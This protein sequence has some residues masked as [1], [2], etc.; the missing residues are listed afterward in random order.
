[1]K[2][3]LFE[4]FSFP[5]GLTLR[6]HVVMAP[7]TTWSANDD[8]TVSGEE[9]SYYRRRAQGVGLVLTGCTHVTANGVGF[10]GEFASYDDKFIPSLRRLAN[11][12][13]SGGAPAVLQ[14][15]HAG[16]KAEPNLVPD[17]DVVSASSVPVAAGP[18]NPGG[19][20]PRPLSHDEIL[21]V[22]SAFGAAT[23]RAIEAGFDGIELHGAHGFLLQNF[24]SPLY[25]Q[26]DDEWGGS[27]ESRMRFPL[28]VVL[29]VK[30]VIGQ[31]A[32]RPFLLGYRISPEESEE[33]GLRI[34]DAYALI[35]GL[36]ATGVD[37]VHASLTSVLEAKPIDSDD[38][39]TVAELIATR[40]AGRVPVIAA[41][42]IRT[43]E[44]ARS[45]LDLGLSL[46]AV[47]QGLVINPNW[48]E[49]SKGGSEHQIEVEVRTSK[50]PEIE[51]PAKL[52]GVIQ[53]ATGWFKVNDDLPEQSKR[54]NA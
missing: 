41:G 3:T 27:P 2:A 36:I 12:A 42:Q 10:T 21:D 11:A 30:R 38:D 31:F 35:D 4:P 29:E 34:D 46:V 47:G 24:F 45:A 9:T 6:N 25:N 19:V 53:A 50:V 16:N 20:T 15:F 39:R 1:M 18:F 49:L 22:I 43:S 13:K 51:L 54:A 32:K 40:V 48:I 7:M 23:R 44:Q 14:I 17:G 5:N 33:G 8:E 26:R 52:W 28:A 37:Y